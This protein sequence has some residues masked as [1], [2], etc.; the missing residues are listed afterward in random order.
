MLLLV[1]AAGAGWQVRLCGFGLRAGVGNGT[2]S[3]MQALRCGFLILSVVFFVSGCGRAKVEGRYRDADNPA[4][5][6]DFRADRTWTAE[7]AV[8]VAAGIFPHGS[9][10]KFEGTLKQRGDVIELTCTNVSRQEPLT[11][12]FRPEPGRPS[13]YDHKFR[14]EEGMLR[15]LAPDAGTE[16]LF[17]SDINPL[18]AKLLMPQGD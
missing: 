18:G 10:R 14:A 16:I 13:A 2:S 8:E 12:E 6:Y 3:G 1:I 17:A 11:G 5:G 9:G 15:P 4:I 7:S